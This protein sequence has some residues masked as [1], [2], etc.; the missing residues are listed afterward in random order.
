MSVPHL[1]APLTIELK[2][3]LFVLEPDMPF[4]QGNPASRQHVGRETRWVGSSSN[5]FPALFFTRTARSSS[6][7]LGRYRV[8]VGSRQLVYFQRDQTLVRAERPT[9]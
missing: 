3:C 7:S 1:F 2:Q 6:R 4:L 5:D 9:M 8:E